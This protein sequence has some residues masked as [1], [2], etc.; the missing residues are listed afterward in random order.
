MAENL[1]K[2]GWS[3]SRP[4]GAKLTRVTMRPMQTALNKRGGN[5]SEFAGESDEVNLSR[6]NQPYHI[7]LPFRRCQDNNRSKHGQAMRRL[8]QWHSRS[9][10]A[11]AENNHTGQIPRRTGFQFSK[12]RSGCNLPKRARLANAPHKLIAF[13]A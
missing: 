1:R 11:F 8:R 5:G 4:R 7:R 10:H 12:N 13:T 9:H 2:I 3:V 6:N